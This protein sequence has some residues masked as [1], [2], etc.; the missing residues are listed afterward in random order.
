MG[1]EEI[2][3]VIYEIGLFA[4]AASGILPDNKSSGTVREQ[5]MSLREPIFD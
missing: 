1:L 3:A 2:I 5:W 4:K